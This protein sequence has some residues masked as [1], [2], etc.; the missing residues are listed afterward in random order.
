MYGYCIERLWGKI[1]LDMLQSLAVL[2][3]MAEK[4]RFKNQ[5]IWSGWPDLK[6]FFPSFSMTAY[7][8][9]STSFVDIPNISVIF[10]QERWSSVTK[11]WSAIGQLLVRAT[12]QMLLVRATWY[13]NLIIPI[14]MTPKHLT[15]IKSKS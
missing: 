4:I 3:K 10:G 14:L 8:R 5:V 11:I 7:D 13:T 9:T 1:C 15:W 12:D 2:W 6:W